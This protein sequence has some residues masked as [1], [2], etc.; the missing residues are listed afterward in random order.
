[1]SIE[2]GEE[3]VFDSTGTRIP[4]HGR[5]ARSHNNNSY[6]PLR[7]KILWSGYKGS[8]RAGFSRNFRVSRNTVCELLC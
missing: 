6:E 4:A 5:P 1:V 8:A 7:Y 2:S 3:K